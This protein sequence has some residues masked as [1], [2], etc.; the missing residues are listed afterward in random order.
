MEEV[1]ETGKPCVVEHIRRDEYGNVVQYA[2]IHA[3]PIFDAEGKVTHM[4]DCVIDITDR[5]RFEETLR[6]SE[7][8]YRSLFQN[9]PIGISLFSLDGQVLQCNWTMSQLTG[10]A[11]AELSNMNIRELFQNSKEYEPLWKRLK[12]NG[13]VHD[14]EVK[15]IRKDGT[16]FFAS[17]TVTRIGLDGSERRSIIS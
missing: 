4:I 7:S 13:F 5:K 14:T 3:H 2:E 11:E 6:E 12:K 10:Y 17:L 8:R 15:L 16:S 1:R 9:I